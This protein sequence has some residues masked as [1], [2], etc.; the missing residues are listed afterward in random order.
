MAGRGRGAEEGEGTTA[1]ASE[2]LLFA[3]T[4][5]ADAAPVS[6]PEPRPAKEIL[7]TDDDGFRPASP[8]ATVTRLR[9]QLG[10]VSWPAFHRS[11]GN[12]ATTE[13]DRGIG[14]LLVPVFLAAGVIFYFS[15]NAEPD[16]Y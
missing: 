12:A 5:P 7:P 14:F 11:I 10:R 15:L 16:L 4:V 1:G 3:D 8:T 6:L 2:R 9:K 13:L